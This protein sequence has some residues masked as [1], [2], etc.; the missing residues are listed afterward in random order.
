MSK[1]TDNISEIAERIY[2]FMDAERPRSGSPNSG[3]ALESLRKNGGSCTNHAILTTALFRAC[4][5][6][7]RVLAC[8]PTWFQG[9]LATHYDVEYYVPSFGW[10]WMDTISRRKDVQPY[11]HVVVSSVMIA[12][13]DNGMDETRYDV[14][15]GVPR[16]TLRER[17]KGEAEGDGG[18]EEFGFA[19]AGGMKEFKGDISEASELAKAVWEKFLELKKA[20][21]E[22]TRAVT[23]QL[24]AAKSQTLKEFTGN[25]TKAL[26]IYNGETVKEEPGSASLTDRILLSV[27]ANNGHF[28]GCT[29][30]PELYE[31]YVFGPLKKKMGDRL[32]TTCE[33]STLENI[34]KILSEQNPFLF[35]WIGGGLDD[36]TIELNKTV[37]KNVD[38]VSV[39]P[40]EEL[41]LKDRIAFIN[42]E[43]AANVNKTLKDCKASFGYWTEM[44]NGLHQATYK[45]DYFSDEAQPLDWYA[46][47]FI[48]MRKVIEDIASGATVKEA[49]AKADIRWKGFL[50]WVK[51]HPEIPFRNDYFEL[52]MDWS[53]LSATIVGNPIGKIEK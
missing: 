22:P 36:K 26:K 14:W 5:I 3:Y 48:N 7:A 2:K 18:S 1:G 40:A 49:A 24:A 13:E 31:K 27:S 30:P 43:F 19:T 12:D 23:F 15:L 16:Y 20:G 45:C 38:F 17:V 50:E 25:L 47:Y 33:D 8:Y 46:P 10:R 6:P 42:C 9:N 53:D 21:K 28:W 11:E 29:T 37:G 4:G 51:K 35:V 41:D 52:K 32:I 34:Q 39:K 44:S